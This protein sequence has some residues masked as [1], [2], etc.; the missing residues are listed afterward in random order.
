MDALK[1]NSWLG[2]LLRTRGTDIFRSKGVLA[3]RGQERRLVFQGVHMMFDGKYERPWGD[4]PRVNTFAFIGRNLDRTS[5]VD[6]F[7]ACL[8][9]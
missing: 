9:N 5:L 4:E 6:G 8:A 1:L 3:V 2:D 7:T